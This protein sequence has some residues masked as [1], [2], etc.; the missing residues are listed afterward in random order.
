MQSVKWSLYGQGS[1]AHFPIFLN[2]KQD[3]EYHL[4]HKL[5]TVSIDESKNVELKDA[6][7]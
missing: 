6:F 1:I 2:Q 3:L 7:I 5:N 4:E